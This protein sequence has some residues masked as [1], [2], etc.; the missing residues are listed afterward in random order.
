VVAG[1]AASGGAALGA[2]ADGVA[3]GR[4]QLATSASN[5]SNAKRM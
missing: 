1:A 4:A 2:E 5:A 3:A